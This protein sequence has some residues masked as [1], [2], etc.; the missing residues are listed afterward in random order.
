MGIS[1]FG[2]KLKG[3]MS[4]TAAEDLF[5]WSAD[6]SLSR[7]I[8]AFS[9]NEAFYASPYENTARHSFNL[10]FMS[11]FHAK[12]DADALYD[13]SKLKQNWKLELGYTP[14]N[15]YI[16]SF[17]I[18]TQILWTKENKIDEGDSYGKIW[19]NSW[20][21]LIPDAGE[22]AQSRKSNAQII[23]TQR[24][25]PVGAVITIDGSALFSSA[26]NSTRLENSA[27][28]DIPVV[29]EKINLNFRT[30]RSFRQQL[31]YSGE[32]AF[33][34]GRLFLDS[35]N[36]SF[37]FWKVIPFYSLFA[38]ELNN[39]M[40]RGLSDSIHSS[41]LQYT[42]FN[43]HFSARIN[44]LSV[45]NLASF[46]LPT[47]INFRLERVLEQKMDTRADVLNVAGSLGFSSINMFGA[48]GYLSLFKFY[49][50]DEF[51]HAIETAFIIPNSDTPAKDSVKDITWRIQ[52]AARAGFR[53][54]DKSIIN[55]VNTF[56]IRKDDSW[57][58]SFN[59]GWEAPAPKSL[60]GLF[61]NWISGL[62]EKQRSWLTLSFGKNL[63]YELLRR[64]SL[65]L[66]FDKTSD[67]LR[68]SLTAGHEEIAIILGRFNLSGFVKLKLGEDLYSEIFTVEA[69]LGISLRISF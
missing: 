26:G 49:Q 42:S 24:T 34:D 50:S 12:F 13:L 66:V 55:F 7:K 51:S 31:D 69:L 48:L 35:A 44:L 28:L 6:H 20:E 5:L 43:D 63:N 39:T 40:D 61:Y 65:E 8:G 68:W 52:S 21:H 9:L 56:T 14:R 1:L 57:L 59:A 37:V 54:V 62:L 60:I 11:D 64:E 36:D 19:V 29:T 45:Y 27:F 10:G 3:N 18:N 53:L 30:G 4:F 25:K 38:P 67:Y 33:D 58:E 16:P 46:L 41:I 47:K 15:Q 32:N 22:G 23:L 2:I 17:A